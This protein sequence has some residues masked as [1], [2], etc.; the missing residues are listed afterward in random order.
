MD[1]ERQRIQ[2]DLAG[3][4]EGEVRCDPLTVAM[5]SSDASLY[6]VTPLG[7]AFPRCSEDVIALSEYASET[8]TSLTARGA[9]TGL[10]GSALGQGI[11]VD[12]SR[13]MHRIEHIDEKTVRVQP[14]VVRDQLNR[15]LREYG[16]YFPPDPSNT[17]VT[18]V[19]GMLAVDAA[20]SHSVR[21][22]STRD[23]VQ[24][25]DVV[26]AGGRQFV[27][28]NESLDFIRAHSHRNGTSE[29][30]P[31]SDT[32]QFKRTLL[33]K[34]TKLLSDNQQLLNEHQPPLIRNC[35]GYYLRNVLSDSH[36]N[37]AR[38]LVGSEGTLGLFTNATLHT[39]PLP[40]H[41]GVALLLFGHLDSAVSAVLDITRQQPSA[42]DLL[43][44][45]LLSLARE[46]DPRFSRIV[47]PA[48]EA[49]LIVEQTGFSDNQVRDR[50]R[51]VIE[52]ARQHDRS[53]HVAHLALDFDDV[54]FLWS[55]PGR[56]VPTL[57][58]LKGESRP[59]PFV[60]DIAV[61]PELLNEFLVESQRVLQR[62]QVTATL[63]AHAAA[64][65]LHLRPFLPTPTTDAAKRRL[66]HIAQDLYEVVFRV[67]GTISGEHGD[68]LSRSGFVQQQYGPLYRVFQEIKHLFDPHNLLNPG[69][70]VNAPTQLIQQH[71]RPLTVPPQVVDL[72]LT[73]NGHEL[74]GAA[75]RCNG[76]GVCR[77]QDPGARMCPFFQ[78]VP[79]E[80]ATPRAKAN[81]LR[82]FSNSL[83]TPNASLN[84]D[85]ERVFEL[86]FN[87][88]QCE[89]ECPSNVDIPQLMLEAKAA[90]VAAHGLSRVDWWLLRGH[91]MSTLG[92]TLALPVNWALSNPLARW[93]LEKV[94][95]IARQRKLPRFA[96]RAFLQSVPRRLQHKP[97]PDQRGRL[98]VYFVDYF[99][100]HHDPQLAQSL[101]SILEH[102]GIAVHVPPDQTAAGVNCIRCG[103]IDSARNLAEQNV[104]ALAG[105]ARD[106]FQ[107][108]CSEPSSALCLSQEYPKL[109]DHPDVPIVASQVIEAGT[110]LRQ[111]HEEGRLK[112]D[113][114]SLDLTV[115]Y[116][117]PCHLKALQVEHPL[118][119]LLTLIPDL[120]V[121][122]LE[123]GCSG[124]AGTYGLS[125][126]SFRSS[127]Q[128]GWDLITEMRLPELQIG[129]TECSS[130][131]MQMEQGTTT[132][133]LHPL[134]LLAFA[135]GLMPEIGN[136]LQQSTRKLVT[137]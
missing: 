105:F 133:T 3:L 35:C 1:E 49:A 63:Y 108:I 113:F 112:T 9:G 93:L 17:E 98:V 54:E 70:I 58:R 11:I 42:C 106:G 132:P 86:C 60:E 67:G 99:A 40:A 125:S 92:N 47:W 76:C 116:H 74:A 46:A 101:I 10:A 104:R 34:L 123:K 82:E 5:Y 37:L 61:P 127:V 83:S 48:A 57:T 75:D 97:R 90:H 87:C 65:Q 26:V 128:I 71:L 107:I 24:S 55:L 80:E 131:K 88:K 53:V 27:A 25:V 124:M 66:E 73:W 115:G 130:C 59:L 77:T 51:M 21:V 32:V 28:G 100:N 7:V 36:L 102:N 33:S 110:Y 95:G 8:G 96:K 84:A 30:E 117:T 62:H 29:A 45:R 134:K 136:Q 4:L 94:V 41:R 23:H 13:Y 19:G 120:R 119:D 69:K 12:F 56:V 137:S 15:V 50:M 22:G 52:A 43:D 121:Q 109:L 89:L 20:G 122:T 135:Q 103:D 38:M 64:G 126:E 114:S 18:T 44:R 85:L 78:A 81:I 14:G 118:R 72:Q 16:R 111:L 79:L 39:A 129:T 2:E 6:Q 68:G 91:H 31:S